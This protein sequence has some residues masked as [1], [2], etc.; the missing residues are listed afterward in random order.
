M[1]RDSFGRFYYRFPEGES[2]LDVYNRV[3]AF[4]A[5]L[6]REWSRIPNLEDITVIM[7][8]HGLS[9]RLFIMRWF[10]YTVSDFENS[11]N[12]PNGAV[13]V[14]NRVDDSLGPYFV[15]D[16]EGKRICQFQ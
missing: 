12:P 16:E 2:G 8:C 13:I 4:I 1:E 6:Y 15:I 11:R 5:T 10:R 9:L 3:T 14:L 7:V